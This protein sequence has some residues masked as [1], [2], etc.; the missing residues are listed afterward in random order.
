MPALGREQEG[1]ESPALPWQRADKGEHAWDLSPGALHVYKVDVYIWSHHAHALLQ[2][3]K[4]AFL[5]L[6]CVRVT[7]RAPFPL[8]GGHLR[9]DSCVQ[10]SGSHARTPSAFMVT[11]QA[12]QNT[13]ALRPLK[14]CWF[15]QA[16]FPIIVPSGCRRAIKVGISSLGLHLLQ[17][18]VVCHATLSSRLRWG[19]LHSLALW[20]WE[21]VLLSFHSHERHLIWKEALNFVKHYQFLFYSRLICRLGNAWHSK[22]NMNNTK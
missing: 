22:L 11:A 10:V 19:W 14:I 3:E 9:W 20:K 12:L 17:K 16:K 7:L 6:C 21:L 13:A 4:R 1:E 15:N 2:S 8:K 5:E 18:R